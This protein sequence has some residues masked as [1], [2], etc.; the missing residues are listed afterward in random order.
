MAWIY[1]I[2]AGILEIFWAVGLK[3]THGFTK[4]LPSLAVLAV[5]AV[6]FYFLSQ[7]IKEIPVGT[8]YAVWTGIGAAGTALAGIL[9]FQEPAHFLRLI[10][11]FLILAGVAGLKVFH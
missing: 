6:S 5:M 8:A 11:I 4:P 10:C 9:F 7:A 3:Y 1:L 2:T